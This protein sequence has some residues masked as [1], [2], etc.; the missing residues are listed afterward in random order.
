MKKKPY[1]ANVGMNHWDGTRGKIATNTTATNNTAQ[2]QRI[3]PRS[4]RWPNSG[5]LTTDAR[6]IAQAESKTHRDK[7]QTQI[8]CGEQFLPTNRSF[9]RRLSSRFFLREPGKYSCHY[10]PQYSQFQDGPAPT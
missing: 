8:R 3:R 2:V 5:L 6:K 9:A 10:N 7:Q 1:S 4:L